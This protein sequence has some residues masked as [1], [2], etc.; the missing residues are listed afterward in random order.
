M[1]AF[2]TL[3]FILIESAKSKGGECNYKKHLRNQIL[4]VLRNEGEELWD[5]QVPRIGKDSAEVN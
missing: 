2:N 4:N 5:R 3:A 1:F